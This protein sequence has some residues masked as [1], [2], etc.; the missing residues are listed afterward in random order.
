VRIFK[1]G[2]EK[3]KEGSMRTKLSRFLL[4]YR[5]TPHTTT[6]VAQAAKLMMGRHLRTQLDLIQPNL[7]D[8]V[9]EKQS[10]Q[11]AVPDSLARLR[12]IKTGNLVYAKDFRKPKSWIPG[13]V[14][15]TTGPV[16]AEIQLDDGPIIPCHQDNLRILFDVPQTTIASGL[17]DIHLPTR[18]VN[19]AEPQ[20]EPELEARTEQRRQPH[21]N[22]LLPQ[23]LQ[24]Y[25][26]ANS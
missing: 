2:I 6:G 23:H 7:G 1:E 24:D 9:R 17:E 3:M 8:R 20:K 26:L 15:K 5:I 18:Q 10:Q 11:K 16:S 14:V 21:R 22:R 4:K 12:I 13:T 19:P 25:E